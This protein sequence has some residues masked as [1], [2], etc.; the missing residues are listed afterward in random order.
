MASWELLENFFIFNVSLLAM[1][2]CD[3]DEARESE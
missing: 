3:I 2:K 1:D